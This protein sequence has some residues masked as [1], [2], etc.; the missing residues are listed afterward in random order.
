MFFQKNK[1]YIKFFFSIFISI[2][3]ICPIF[4]YFVLGNDESFIKQIYRYSAL[5]FLSAGFT[6]FSGTWMKTM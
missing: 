2:L 3:V 1:K 6:T 4:E 5:G